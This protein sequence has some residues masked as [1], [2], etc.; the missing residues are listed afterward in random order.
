MH[1]KTRQKL[2]GRKYFQFFAALGL[3]GSK[4]WH[5]AE[6]NECYS[7][8]E[9]FIK[10]ISVNIRSCLLVITTLLENKNKKHK[11]FGPYL[12]M[13]QHRCFSI[14]QYYKLLPASK[15]NKTVLC[16]SSH[17]AQPSSIKWSAVREYNGV[18]TSNKTSNTSHVLYLA[19]TFLHA[20]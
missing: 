7:C 2:I 14:L 10:S 3:K 6:Y 18:A 4:V 1:S 13:H 15:V 20:P 19:L 9:M 16:Q 17:C 8:L 11:A 5:H 12:A